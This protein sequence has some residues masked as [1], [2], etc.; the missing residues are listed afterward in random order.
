MED[1]KATDEFIIDFVSYACDAIFYLVFPFFL[2]YIF[3]PLFSL[4]YSF[5]FWR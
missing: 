5:F 4:S 2:F 3:I 1:R